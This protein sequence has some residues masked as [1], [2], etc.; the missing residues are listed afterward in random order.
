M[1]CKSYVKSLLRAKMEEKNSPGFCSV[2]V[3]STTH[4]KKIRYMLV[5]AF[6]RQNVN[7]VKSPIL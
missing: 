4:Y 2:I 6:C 1:C 3:N 7:E 5:L